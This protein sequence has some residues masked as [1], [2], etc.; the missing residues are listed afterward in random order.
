MSPA[1]ILLWQRL[2]GSPGGIRFRKQHPA[3]RFVLD[4]FCA[5]ANLAIE[6]DGDA[7]DMG[8]QPER[9]TAR[10]AWLHEHRIVTLRI[11]A[12]EVFADPDEIAGAIVEVARERLIAFGKLGTD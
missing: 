10:D 1:E 9:D 7:H 5:R 6:V 3:G 2:K 12:N 11:P 4:F 8:D